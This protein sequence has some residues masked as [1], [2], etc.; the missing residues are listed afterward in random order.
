MHSFATTYRK[1]EKYFSC[2]QLEATVACGSVWGRIYNY[3]R[4]A[5][6]YSRP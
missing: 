3:F 5:T 1:T 4:S 6:Y 2:R